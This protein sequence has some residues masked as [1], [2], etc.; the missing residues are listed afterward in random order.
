MADVTDANCTC[1]YI[2]DITNAATMELKILS[3]KDA[4]SDLE[5]CEIGM[6]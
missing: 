3:K 6:N 4:S 1:N 5:I 2:C